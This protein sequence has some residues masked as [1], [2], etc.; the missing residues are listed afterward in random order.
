MKLVSLEYGT[1]WEIVARVFN[2]NSSI[3]EEINV[4]IIANI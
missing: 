3:F 1:Q 4:K 2:I